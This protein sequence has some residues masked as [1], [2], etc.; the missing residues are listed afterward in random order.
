VSA[1][2]IRPN[3]EN[4]PAMWNVAAVGQEV[5]WSL[6]TQHGDIS[7]GFGPEDARAIGTALLAAAYGL[8][9]VL[10]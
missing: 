10:P 5:M 1:H 3:R 2:P 7:M 4:A 8:D 6:V 9:Q